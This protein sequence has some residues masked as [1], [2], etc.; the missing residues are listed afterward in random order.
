MPWAENATQGF[1]S[2]RHTH[3]GFAGPWAARDGHC[4]E[5]YLHF[6]LAR[7]MGVDK[8]MEVGDGTSMTGELLFAEGLH[9]TLPIPGEC[10]EDYDAQIALMQRIVHSHFQSESIR[11]IW[12]ATALSNEALGK[13]R[14]CRRPAATRPPSSV[15]RDPGVL[16]ERAA[17]TGFHPT[18]KLPPGSHPEVTQEIAQRPR[19]S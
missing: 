18:W 14:T 6:G 8:Y 9:G 3:R 16:T 12:L 17:S 19:R 7:V 5:A 1:G 15:T 13:S 11:S 10:A 4:V 2:C